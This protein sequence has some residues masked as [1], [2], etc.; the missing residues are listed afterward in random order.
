MPLPG[1]M[2][3]FQ[4]ISIILGTL[5]K[6]QVQNEEFPED[7]YRA[8]LYPPAR[9]AGKGN[10][11]G[12]RPT[13]NIGLQERESRLFRSRADAVQFARHPHYIFG[14]LYRCQFSHYI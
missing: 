8:S 9:Q 7:P 10:P 12:T 11:T 13:G 1:K 5:C 4:V 2:I 6:A 3:W 14:Q